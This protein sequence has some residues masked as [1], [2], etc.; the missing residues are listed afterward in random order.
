MV[1]SLHNHLY[2]I[3][4][5]SE[6]DFARAW[7]SQ[8]ERGPDRTKSRW[9]PDPDSL[10]YPDIGALGSQLERLVAQVPGDRFKVILFDDLQTDPGGVFFSVTEFLALGYH[11]PEDFGARNSAFRTRH[12]SVKVLVQFLSRVK[13]A[14]GLRRGLGILNH[15]NHWNRVLSVPTAVDPEFREELIAWFG[16]EVDKVSEVLD[17]DLS[18]WKA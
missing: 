6:G 10:R 8:L 11:P 18:H 12:P 16:K 14:F 3:G 9:N 13:Q 2:Q 7:R 4:V 15:L 5:E 17:R 1:I